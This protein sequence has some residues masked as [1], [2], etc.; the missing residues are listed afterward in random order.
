MLGGRGQG[1]GQEQE[2]GHSDHCEHLPLIPTLHRKLLLL[3]PPISGARVRSTI[4]IPTAIQKSLFQTGT[5]TA[6]YLCYVIHVCDV[7]RLLT[8]L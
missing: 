4:Q 1:Q 7:R 3:R 6:V 8:R 2:Q 5:G